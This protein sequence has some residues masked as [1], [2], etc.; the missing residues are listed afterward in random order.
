LF[1]V[2]Q[3]QLSHALWSAAKEGD[4]AEILNLI[5]AGAN[6]AENLGCGGT[7]LHSAAGC[8]R[9]ETCALLIREYARANGSAKRFILMGNYMRSTALHEAAMDG[10]METCALLLEECAKAGGDIRA[11]ISSKNDSGRD[12]HNW[13]AVRSHD[14]TAQFIEFA[15]K[16]ADLLAIL[17]EWKLFHS[18]KD[19]FDECVA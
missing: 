8:G 19:S 12:A 9:T 14:K 7:S 16:F 5:R 11:F 18:F 17:P 4:N 2:N 15:E 3:Y 10:H 6:M 13:A 1:V